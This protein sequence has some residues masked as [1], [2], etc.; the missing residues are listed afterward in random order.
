MWRGKKFIIIAVL[1]AV[2]LVGTLGG[3]ALAQTGDEDNNPQDQGGAL[4]DKVCAIYEENTGVAIDQ[5]ALREAFAQAQDEMRTEALDNYLQK[6]VE[7][8]KLTQEQADQYKAWLEARPDVPMVAGMGGRG[9]FQG[10][11][12]PGGFGPPA[13]PEGFKPPE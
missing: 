2:V 13:L 10:F 11:G 6:L 3:V 9:M 12:G 1:T 5:E 7:E 4:L 8:G